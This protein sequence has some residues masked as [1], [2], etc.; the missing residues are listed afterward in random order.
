ME[1][2]E[3]SV[4]EE[5]LSERRD[6]YI[7]CEQMNFIWSLPDVWAIDDMWRK[8]VSLVEM[9]QKIDRDPDEVFILLMDRIRTNKLHARP[10]GMFGGV[11]EPEESKDALT[12]EVYLMERSRNVSKRQIAKKYGLSRPGLRYRLDKWGIS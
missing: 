6:R 11:P 9:A 2:D 7:A 8:G 12:K 4:T 3:M 10:G 1:G 5:T